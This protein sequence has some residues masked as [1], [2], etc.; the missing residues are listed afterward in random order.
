MSGAPEPTG[1]LEV[2]LAHAAKLL[3]SDPALAGEQATEILKVAPGHPVATIILG[4]SHRA[5]GD[6]PSALAILEPLAAAHPSWVSTHYELGLAYGVAGRSQ[7]AVAAL[8][9]AVSIRPDMGDAWRALGDH[10]TALGDTERADEAY[11][12]HIKASTRDPR[13]LAP[14]AA[15]CEGRI[16]VA[17]KLLRDHLKRFPTDVVAIR[18]LAEVAARL[19][20]FADS[21]TLLARCLELAPG[22]HAARHNY[23]VVLHRQDRLG[24][25]L[26]EVER[27]LAADPRDTGGRNLKAALLGKLGEAKQ[28]AEI[29]RQVLD[30]YPENAS[31]W[32]S[33]GHALKT[34]GLQ[35]ESIAA[36]R[37]S[38]Q[39]TPGFGEAYWSLANLKTFRFEARD[40]EAMLHQLERTDL[41]IEDRFHFHFALGKALEDA[42]EYARSFDHYAEGNRLRRS[43]IDYDPDE[44][45]DRVGQMKALLTREFLASRNGSGNPAPDPIFIVGLPRAGSTLVEQILSSHSA[46]EGTMELPDIGGI[47]RDLGGRKKRKDVSAYPGV[48]AEMGDDALRALGDRYL[49]QTR[50]QRKTAAPYFIDKMP[51]NW[52]HVG[53]IHLILPNARIVDARRHPMS[54]CFSVFKQH[55]ARGQRYTYDLT[56][57]GR[58]YRDYVDLM[59]HFDEV[60]PGRVHRVYYDQMVDDTQTEVR[61]LLDYCGLPFEDGCLRFYENERAVRT[62][63]SEQ[64]RKPIY[65]DALHQWMN[66]QPWL[67]PLEKA[68]GPALENWSRSRSC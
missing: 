7:D 30:E 55:F 36:Y 67:G 25:A 57:L 9:R 4:A 59:A 6:A 43:V 42:G 54:C 32:Q 23:A 26:R 50:I 48:L 12:Q 61:R 14:A 66:Y 16:A 51:N 24:E 53:L 22:F 28:S 15:L 52:A 19:G 60:L 18:M 39:V 63:S 62:A 11:A 44:M 56:E 8:R 37:R 45:T 5:R 38:T 68:L 40:V 34:A 49:T 29:Y 64:V 47:A 3:V 17:E 35:P 2:A 21:E 13:L 58:Y 20:R 1:T 41:T 33:Y 27:L 46:V 31:L 10:L 65:R